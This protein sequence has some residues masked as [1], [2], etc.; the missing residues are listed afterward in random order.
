ML[1]SLFGS[2]LVDIPSIVRPLQDSIDFDEIQL[3]DPL[4]SLNTISYNSAVMLLYPHFKRGAQNFLVDQRRKNVI[5]VF[6]ALLD[7]DTIISFAV[8]L[9]SIDRLVQSNALAIDIK[10][11]DVENQSNSIF[12]TSN[13]TN[14]SSRDVIGPLGSIMTTDRVFYLG[15]R[16]VRIQMLIDPNVFDNSG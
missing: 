12:Q 2:D 13:Y 6:F 11:K 9:T 4:S 10:G 15:N 16:P 5:G 7:L 8:R 14:L 1:F 3:S